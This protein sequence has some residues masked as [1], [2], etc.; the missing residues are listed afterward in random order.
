MD[1]KKIDPESSQKNEVRG[2][3][4]HEKKTVSLRGP[5]VG[6][7]LGDRPPV[8]RDQLEFNSKRTV[9]GN[10]EGPRHR[11]EVLYHGGKVSLKTIGEN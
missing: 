10:R 8:P 2:N 4:T 7:G 5:W 9:R 11:L 3:M 6:S 1:G